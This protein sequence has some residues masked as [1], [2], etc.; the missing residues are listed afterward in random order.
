MHH[1]LFLKKSNLII[2][3]KIFLKNRSKKTT[4]PTEKSTVKKKASNKKEPNPD[5]H[6]ENGGGK[7]KFIYQ[8]FLVLTGLTFVITGLMK[9]DRNELTNILKGYGA[10]VT[11]SVSKKTTYLAIGDVL[12]DGRQ[13]NESKKYKTAEEL[14]IKILNYDELQ[15]LLR[16]KL[17]NPDFELDSL[18]WKTAKTLEILKQ[19][20]NIPTDKPM[21]FL[22]NTDDKNVTVSTIKLPHT[23]SNIKQDHK[24]DIDSEYKNNNNFKEKTTIIENDNELWTTKYTPKNVNEFIGNP[25]NISKIIQWLN[26]WDDVV[27]RGN[28]K[29]NNESAKSRYKNENPNSKALLISGDPGVGK[30]SSI[31]LLGKLLNYKVFELNA[32]DQR[33]KNIILKKVGFLTDNTTLDSKKDERVNQKNLIVMDEIDGMAGNEDRGGVAALI[34]IIKNTKVPIICICNDR[35]NQKLKSL[36]NYCYDIKFSK[37]DKRQITK[38]MVEICN[39][40]GLKVEEN[41]IENLCE[42]VGNDI[43]QCLNF[44]QFWSRKFTE[45]KFFDMKNHFDKFSKDSLVMLNHFDAVTKLLTRVS[46]A[47]FNFREKLN[48]FFLDYDLVPLLMHENYLSGFKEKNQSTLIKIAKSSDHISFGDILDKRIR[49]N[50]Q[51]NLL[52][53][54]GIHS[55]VAVGHYSANFLGFPKFPEYKLIIFNFY[56]KNSFLFKTKKY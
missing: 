12:E 49:T 42:S 45:L 34:Q 26:D 51:W 55:S 33:N 48:M 23:E 46:Y 36:A 40:E 5:I 43:R 3:S 32:S 20:C 54:K 56:E 1:H 9:I 18:D 6:L 52:Q 50:N 38:R 37:P 2:F 28:L 35:Q 13:V 17:D 27:L 11:G 53:D 22:K 29:E 31:R 14:K 47:K 10:K 7:N 15:E 8:I 30:T 41:A 24:M 44:L 39:L 21:S 4:K 19:N 25:S 16:E